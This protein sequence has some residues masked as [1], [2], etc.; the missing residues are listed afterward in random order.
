MRVAVGFVLLAAVAGGLWFWQSGA[1]AGLTVWAVE[2]QRLIQNELARLVMAE[3]RGD[4]DVVG[5]LIVASAFYGFVHAV[6]PGHGKFLIG[7][8][9]IG[10]GAR[11]R[12]MAL[13]AVVSSLAQGAVAVLLV[14]GGLGLLSLGAGW[15]VDTTEEVLTPL[16]YVV[17]AVIGAVLVWRGARAL[18]RS[19]LPARAAPAVAHHHHEP[20]CGCGHRHGPTAEEVAKVRGWRDALALVAAIALRPCT[21]AVMVLVIAW[22]TGLHALGIG[23]VLAMALGTGILT[24]AVA[25]ASV[26]FRRASFA[27]SGTPARLAVVAPALQLAAGAVVLMLSLGLLAASLGWSGA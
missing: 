25:L 6:G 1:Y 27:V 5:G 9:G 23:A 24:V 18:G 22:Q 4:A 15:A 21:G 17:I 3:R 19:V 10:G 8:A 14:Y 13:L 11:A 2:Q 26:A 16:S 12:T 20:A 7:S